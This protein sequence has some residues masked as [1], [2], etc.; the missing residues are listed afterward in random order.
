[1]PKRQP[2]R[3]GLFFSKDHNTLLEPVYD[4]EGCGEKR[5]FSEFLAQRI[6][7]T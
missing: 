2:P 1:M 6:F 4:L 7:Y 3:Q 5:D